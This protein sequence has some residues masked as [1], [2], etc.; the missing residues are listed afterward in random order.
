MSAGPFEDGLATATQGDYETALKLRLPLAG[1]G[2]AAAQYN[3]GLM[4]D[5][6]TGVPQDYAAAEK[7]YGLAA[8]QGCARAEVN[9]DEL[10]R[11]TGG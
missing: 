2:N 1:Q 6:G 3:L 10:R 4:H 5:D 9:L 7:W 8:G 11:K